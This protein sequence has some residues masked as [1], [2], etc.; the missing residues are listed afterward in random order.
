VNVVF[1]IDRKVI[2]D[3]QRHLLDINS[4]R[5]QIGGNQNT[6]RTTPEFLHNDISLRLVHI[7]VHRADREIFLGQFISQPIDLSACVAKDDGLSN[8]DGFI[9]IGEC[10]EFPI[11][12]FNGNVKLFDP[13]E[14]ELILFDEDADGVAHKLLSHFEDVGGHRCREENGLGVVREELE[15][16]VDLIFETTLLLDGQDITYRKHFIRLV[17]DKHFNVVGAES[18][19]VLDHVQN[20]SGGADDNVNTFLKD[21]DIFTDN[22]TSDTGVAL[23]VNAE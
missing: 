18:T 21:P 19:T 7:A 14:S 1:T 17:K 16:V 5:Q 12:L 4:P 9:Q 23:Q 13:F 2:V 6:G 8:S 3:Y 15:D 22:C 10:I 20:T 11:F